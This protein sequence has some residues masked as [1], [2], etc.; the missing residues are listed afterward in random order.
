DFQNRAHWRQFRVNGGVWQDLPLLK[1]VPL[2]NGDR[3]W[4]TFEV[5]V[6]GIVAGDN[7]I[8]FRYPTRPPQ[9]TWQSNGFRVKDIEIQADPGPD[10]LVEA[11]P[12]TQ[13]ASPDT[14]VTLSSDVPTPEPTNPEHDRQ[15]NS[16]TS[17]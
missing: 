5:P 16:V 12:I 2:T 10:P 9:A 1:N 8:E 6:S 4:S 7:R 17:S 11:A 13:Q 3:G 14:N 15:S